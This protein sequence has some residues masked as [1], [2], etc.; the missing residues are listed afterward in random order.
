M[1]YGSTRRI[2]AVDGETAEALHEVCELGVGRTMLHADH[3]LV[4][5]VPNRVVVGVEALDL[6]DR[7]L[8][9]VGDAVQRPVGRRHQTT[10]DEVCLDELVDGFPVLVSGRVEEDDRHRDA[11]AGLGQ[12]QQLEGLVER[13]EPAWQAHE[14]GALL[15]QHQLAGEEVL[16]ADVLGVTGDHEVGGGLERQPDRDADRPLAPGTQHARFHDPGAG[17]GDHHP[18]GLGQTVGGRP[19]LL[20]E[21]VFLGRAGGPEDADLANVLV[22]GEHGECVAH[23]GD[24]RGGDLEI[25]RVRMIGEQTQRFGEELLGES[26][27]L[28]YPQIGDQAC[29]PFV[30]CVG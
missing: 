29:H 24:R 7:D 30:T 4:A 15:D 12:G 27:V 19:G 25:E 23:L 9:V 28:R 2:V 8:V 1:P 3:E 20:V 21:R 6:A 18:T 14:R 11:L 17:A 26:D 10:P 5:D 13:A 16:H 22:G